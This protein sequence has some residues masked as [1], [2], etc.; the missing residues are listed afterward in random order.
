MVF[1][2]IENTVFSGMKYFVVTDMHNVNVTA[3]IE[4]CFGVSSLLTGQ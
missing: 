4:T 3:V 1:P 2:V